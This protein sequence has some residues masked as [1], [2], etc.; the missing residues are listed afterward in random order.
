MNSMQIGSATLIKQTNSME[1]TNS[2]KKKTDNLNSPMS[3][4]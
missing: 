3:I 4:K 1:N 2:L